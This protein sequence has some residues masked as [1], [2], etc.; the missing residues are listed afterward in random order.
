MLNK[1]KETRKRV[2]DL[3]KPK[4]FAELF[5]CSWIVVNLVVL[6]TYM[7]KHTIKTQRNH[8]KIMHVFE[9]M[10]LA[11][12]IFLR[13][14][15]TFL[16]WNVWFQLFP[17]IPTFKDYQSES[18]YLGYIINKYKKVKPYI[19]KYCNDVFYYTVD[20]KHSDRKIILDPEGQILDDYPESSF[21]G[22]EYLWSL[23]GDSYDIHI[24]CDEALSSYGS[25]LVVKQGD[26]KYKAIYEKGIVKDITFDELESNDL[27]EENENEIR[28]LIEGRT[29][30]KIDGWR[31]GYET[32]IKKELLKEIEN[33][34]ILSMHH[35][36]QMHHKK[37]EALEFASETLEIPFFTT[38]H[39]TSNIFCV[40]AENYVKTTDYEIIKAFHNFAER[41][42]DTNDSKWRTG[43]IFHTDYSKRVSQLS[44][45]QLDA[46]Q[47]LK[48]ML[49][50]VKDQFG[51]NFFQNEFKMAVIQEFG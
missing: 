6:F 12:Y 2:F 11:P 8:E 14:L 41:Y 16:Y 25:T 20:N 22:E 45:K 37:Q 49:E 46:K 31:G 51:S 7:K 34:Q 42:Y 28:A 23:D 47:D 35:S 10:V 3:K 17:S 32:K 19:C 9:L 40:N 1:T 21:V 44:R 43:I 39:R 38:F 5:Y 29:Y 13:D 27:F 48:D 30:Y 50:S 33:F 4:T 26:R 24:G 18:V 15:K 36:E